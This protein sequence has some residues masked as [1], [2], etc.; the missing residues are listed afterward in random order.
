M[1]EFL[2]IIEYNYINTSVL[3]NYKL[4][5]KISTRR[6]NAMTREQWGKAVQT[7]PDDVWEQ[8]EAEASGETAQLEAQRRRNDPEYQKRIDEEV[9]SIREII[10]RQR[11]ADRIIGI[12]GIITFAIWMAFSGILWIIYV[13]GGGQ[14]WSLYMFFAGPVLG[15]IGILFSYCI[16]IRSKE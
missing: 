11:K 4:Y 10:R 14:E 13:L 1:F 5:T 15:L 7:L 6:K 3:W 2:I 9:K 16:L 12:S 8:F